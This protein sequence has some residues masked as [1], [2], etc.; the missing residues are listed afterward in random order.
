MP[1]VMLGRAMSYHQGSES[2]EI[3]ENVYQ[4]NSGETLYFLVVYNIFHLPSLKPYNILN[5]L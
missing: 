4:A 5:N 2:L 1:N 3:L